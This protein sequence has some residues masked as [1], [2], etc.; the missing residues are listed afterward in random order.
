MEKFASSPGKITRLSVA[1][2][3]DGDLPPEQ[4]E[5]IE[6]VVKAAA[7]LSEER[8]DMLIVDLFFQSRDVR[9]RKE[10]LAS[11]YDEVDRAWKQGWVNSTF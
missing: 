11:E 6:G 8:G 2:L 1:V 3:V 4:V 10:S 9:R 7:G 5:K